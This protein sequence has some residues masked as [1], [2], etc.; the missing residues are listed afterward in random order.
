M[1]KS[2]IF[3]TIG[4]LGLFF[5]GMTLMSNGLKQAAGQKLKK[6]LETLTRTPVMGV[7]VGALV[8]CLIQ[9]SGATSV[10]VV[11]L[12][13]AGLLTLRQS[14]G[15]ILGANIGTTITAWVVSLLGIGGLAVMKYALPAIGV[16]FLLQLVGKTQKSRGFG[17]IVL[18]LGLLFLGLT[19]MSDAFGPE[20]FNISESRVVQDALVRLGENP[21]LG[22]L[23]GAVITALLQS[24]SAFVAIVQ[25]LAFK[26]AFGMDW[27]LV[28][29]VVIPFILGSNIGTTITAPL[30]ALPASRNSKRAAMGHVI[31]NV[32]GTVYFLPL[33][34]MGVYTEIVKWVTPWEL[35]QSTIMVYMAVAHSVFNI[36]N[37]IIFLPL[38]GLLEVIVIKLIPVTKRELDKKPVVLE[39]HLFRTPVLALEQ[40]KREIIRMAKKAK[41]AVQQAIKGLLNDDERRLERARAGEDVTDEF[42]LAITSYLVGLSRE[43]LSEEVSRELPVLLHTVNDL[44]RVGDHA[45]NIAEIAER[46]IEQKIIFST[47]ANAEAAKLT[48]EIDRMF[49]KIVAA[50]ENSDIEAAKS[51]LENEKNINKM[52]VDFRRSHVQRMNDGVCGAESGL[53]FIDFVD[54]V[55]KIGDHLTNIA[56]AVIGGLQWDGI[57]PKKVTSY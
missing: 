40:A 4:G 38:I 14:L 45:V 31:F 53:I 29:R 52:Q 33:L 17:N 51:A 16:G 28:L 2:M 54:N 13:N 43:Q 41:E 27:G 49:E 21:L 42:Q 6:L 44:E 24:S 22:V 23:A 36:I 26:G 30:A 56:Q 3:L 50:L 9:A 5:L 48:Q 15:V 10:M 18:G 7:L 57:E 12:V 35:S 25:V 8:T 46:K 55:E 20:G 39:R 47:N 11:G 37:T 34:L 1:I 19:F 32:V